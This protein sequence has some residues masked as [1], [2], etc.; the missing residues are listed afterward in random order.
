MPGLQSIGSCCDGLCPM[1]S[2]GADE[3]DEGASLAQRDRCTCEVH[4][5]GQF[6]PHVPLQVRLRAS[7]DIPDELHEFCSSV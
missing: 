1:E 6:S 3:D 5:E 7:P 2:A 4:Q